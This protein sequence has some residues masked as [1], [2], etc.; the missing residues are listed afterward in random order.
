VAAIL[1]NEQVLPPGLGRALFQT[2]AAIPGATVLPRVTDAAGG[3]GLAVAR[4]ESPA[5][6]QELIFTPGSYR[7]IGVQEILIRP[8]GSLRAGT[9][10]VASSLAD[11]R[12]VNTAP[13]ASLSQSYLPQS[14]GYTPGTIAIGSSGSPSSS[15][16]AASAQA[17][18]APAASPRASSAPAA[19]AA[20][21][22]SQ[23][24]SP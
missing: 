15:A 20:S 19:P 22:S 14:C 16:P 4:N 17:S 11:A 3:R 21:A 5:L 24:P 8:L 13:V 10:W 7:F 2:A 23:T 12:I 6:R 1:G 18:S 9:V